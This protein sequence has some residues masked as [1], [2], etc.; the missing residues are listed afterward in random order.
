MV[1]P[2]SA[3]LVHHPS[4]ADIVLKQLGSMTQG[5]Y[6]SIVAHDL[7]RDQNWAARFLT[8]DPIWTAQNSPRLTA[9][10]MSFPTSV[11]KAVENVERLAQASPKLTVTAQ[12]KVFSDL[13]AA[14]SSPSAQQSILDE[15]DDLALAAIECNR[16]FN[17]LLL[18]FTKIITGGASGSLRVDMEGLVGKWT[19]TYRKYSSALTNSSGVAENAERTAIPGFQNDCTELLLDPSLPLEERKHLIRDWMDI[20]QDEERNAR[21]TGSSFLDLRAEVE[22]SSAEWKR[23]AQK[24]KLS[25]EVSVT[26]ASHHDISLGVMEHSFLQMTLAISKLSSALDVCPASGGIIESLGLL[27]PRFYC[28]SS[29]DILGGDSRMSQLKESIGVLTIQD[30]RMNGNTRSYAPTS[31]STSTE[32]FNTV[33]SRLSAFEAIWSAIAADL[34]SI[35]EN[36]ERASNTPGSTRLF[37]VRLKLLSNAYKRFGDGC[38][39]YR[40]AISSQL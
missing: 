40:D 28:L 27:S 39:R 11:T 12:L 37:E 6:G 33:A 5:M 21:V 34:V 2:D 14:L 9:P 20:T 31:P 26:E 17:R 22:Q 4:I 36:L 18:K 1:N 38:K 3:S 29:A 8:P 23:I 13:A 35:R 32:E 16:S 30:Q 15:I 24:Y 7:K 19:A 10:T 25:D